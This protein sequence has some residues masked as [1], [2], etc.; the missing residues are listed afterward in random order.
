MKNF[1]DFIVNISENRRHD[2][3]S[4]AIFVSGGPGSGKDV[5]IRDV[6][7][8]TDISELNHLQVY[9]FLADKDN[10]LSKSKDYRMES[11]RH[12]MPLVINAPAS[13]IDKIL[14][15][16]EELEEFGYTTIMVYTNTSDQVSK[17]RNEK[18]S[19]SMNES[20]RHSRWLKAQENKDVFSDSF[21]NYIEF[22]N[23]GSIEELSEEIQKTHEKINTFLGKNILKEF[24]KKIN[25]ALKA[26]GPDDI[27]PDNRS[28]ERVDNI[29]YDAPKKTKTYTFRTYSEAS[30]PHMTYSPPP[31]EPNFNKDNDKN[32]KLKRGDK[33][34]SAGRVG[35]PSGIGPEYDTR[36]GGQGA[37]A[38]AGLGNQTYSEDRDFNN[39]D[40][41][42]FAGMTKGASPN[43]LSSSYDVEKKPF[44]KFKKSLK[45]FNGFQND[46]DGMGVGGVLG[47]ASNKE[48]MQSYKDQNRN[49]GITIKKKKGKK[50]V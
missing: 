34:L 31:K 5:I 43:P 36:A 24:K 26:D 22:N 3:M 46:A 50:D 9:N 21:D 47:G 30:Q 12:R 39:D 38:G 32:K 49:I 27:T 45:E 19:R 18:L 29:K 7:S 13:D 10:M 8:E 44:K 35:R 25:P 6:L 17:E 15:I 20:V 48:P 23:M 1:K 4:K 2:T 11:I 41:I 33:S 37:A 42:N 40:V 14:Y 28:S 16:K